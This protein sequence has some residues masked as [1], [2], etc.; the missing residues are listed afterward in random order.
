MFMYEVGKSPIME[1][2]EIYQ[3]KS[4]ENKMSSDNSDNYSVQLPLTLL[5]VPLCCCE[6][7]LQEKFV[8]FVHQL[9]WSEGVE[10]EDV[11]EGLSLLDTHRAQAISTVYGIVCVEPLLQLHVYSVCIHHID[12][13]TPD[14]TTEATQV[15]WLWQWL[16]QWWFLCWNGWLVQPCASYLV[17]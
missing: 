6:G 17:A 3:N 16:M 11:L 15:H 13:Y 2:G 5:N 12:L 8:S 9:R 4:T 1:W 14:Q 7:K 10:D